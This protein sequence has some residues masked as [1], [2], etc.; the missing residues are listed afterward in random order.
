MDTAALVVDA[1]AQLG[2]TARPLDD[3]PGERRVELDPAGVACTVAIARR[4]LVTADIAERLLAEPTSPDDSLLVVADRVTSAARTTL[5]SRRSGYLDLRGRLAVRMDHLVVDADVLPMQ[6]RAVRTKALSGKVGL[7]VAT[8]LLLQP[9]RPSSVR[10]L[11]RELQRS[12]S[13]VS[14]VLTALRREHLIDDNNAVSD[15]RLFWMVAERWRTP[16]VNLATV[17]PIDDPSVTVP[18]QVGLGDVEHQA[19]WALTDSAAAVAYGAPIALRAETTLDFYV[20]DQLVVRRAAT[21][22]GA[23]NANDHARATVRVAPVPAVVR[24]RR[25]RGDGEDAQWPLAHPV[26][27]A[28]DL[29]QDAGRGREIL[30]AW[31]R[32]DHLSDVWTDTWTGAWTDA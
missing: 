4:S 19:G 14:E 7:E 22:L 27:V 13:T 17:P 31:Q 26:F 28:L 11:A 1:F 6:A 12:A 18:L 29:A 2:I 24:Q 32:D 30:N 3:E 8:A 9:R 21:L 20:P 5:T 16:R 10:G 25:R 23:A 15:S